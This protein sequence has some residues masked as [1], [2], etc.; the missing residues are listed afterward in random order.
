MKRRV[1]HVLPHETLATLRAEGIRYIAINTERFENAMGMPAV[2]W[3]GKDGGV[4][5]KR[6]SLKLL[7]RL[8]P[9]EWWIVEIPP[10]R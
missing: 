6:I 7:A 9:D 3:V 1:R 8:D 10:T 2:N 5:R 4:I